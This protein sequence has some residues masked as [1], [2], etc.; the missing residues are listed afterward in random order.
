MCKMQRS[1]KS[2]R[3]MRT[4]VL[5]SND[6]SRAVSLHERII[7]GAVP[8]LLLPVRH[9]FCFM[10]AR[11]PMATIQALN[12]YVFSNP[13]LRID[14]QMLAEKVSVFFDRI[15]PLGSKE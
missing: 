4:V 6:S 14:L 2:E 12:E 7:R 9:G 13:S 10:G 11:K 3:I 8:R 15:A 5:V 1:N